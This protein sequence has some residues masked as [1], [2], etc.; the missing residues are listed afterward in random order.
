MSVS[1][2]VVRALVEAVE[3]A[4]HDGREFLTA[5]GFDP[6]RLEETDGRLEQSEYDSLVEHA[7]RSTGDP[8]LGLR[9][10][11]S[12]TSLAYSLVGH[13]V[14]QASTMREGLEL[15]GQYH[16]LFSDERGFVLEEG[17]RVAT[18][19]LTRGTGSPGC[20]R[21]RAE[22]ALA[23][24]YKMVQQF[25]RDAQPDYVAFEHASPPEREEYRRIFNG[26]ERFSQPFSGVVMDRKLLD[27]TQLN[28]DEG[29]HA[30]SPSA[31]GSKRESAQLRP[32]GVV[33]RKG[34][35]AR[36][37][38]TESARH[39]RGRARSQ[40]QPALA[41]QGGCSKKGLP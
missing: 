19:R 10:V 25:A 36:D 33:R 41:T 34:S 21:F 12:T 16:R 13:L 38:G 30:A 29:V 9:M 17:T 24:M 2:V 8:A 20:R 32:H 3:T 14:L 26:R 28:R 37:D 18:M 15:L 35:R 6:R 5:A 31:S 23:G 39:A 7:L 22:V 27:V 11:Q 1:I 4:R 40:D